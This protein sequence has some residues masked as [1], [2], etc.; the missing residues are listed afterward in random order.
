MRLDNYTRGTGS[1]SR[2]GT[3]RRVLWQAVAVAVAA[4][5][6]ALAC[7]PASSTPS[8]ASGQ[9]VI[10]PGATEP[11]TGPSAVPTATLVP[12]SGEPSLAGD[13]YL[14]MPISLEMTV[15]CGFCDAKGLL[16]RQP[17]FRLYADG[18]AVFREASVEESPYRYVQLGD[19]DFEALLRYALDEGGL[20][21]AEPRYP[22]DA[23]DIGG[24]R[25]ALHAQFI[26]DDADVDVEISP[27]TGDGDIDIHGDPIED[28]PRRGQLL[29]FAEV[30]GDFD[31]WLAGRGEASQLFVPESYRAA[32]VDRFAG[33][34]EGPWPWDDIAP[35]A[36]AAAGSGVSLAKISPAQAAQAG[37]GPG[38]GLFENRYLG[39]GTAATL[40]I[41]PVLPGE[42][43]PGGFGLQPDTVAI[44]V[45][46]DLRVRSLPEV[47][48]ASTKL[49]PLLR[50][51]DAL[52]VIVGPVVG[53]GYDWYEVYA[54]RTGLSGWVAAAAREGDDWIQP[55]PLTCTLGASPDAVVA[56]IG[57]ELMHLACY[58]GVEMGGVRFLGR[59]EGDGLRCP[60]VVEWWFAPE[61]LDGALTCS[62]E[63][64]PEEADTGSFDL[65]T[66]GAIHP[67]IA[68]VPEALLEAHPSG[69][70]VEIVGQLD[71]PDARA[72]QA[73][74]DNRPPPAL[75]RL[76]CRMVF[77]ITEMRPAT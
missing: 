43:R 29:E 61:W 28:L 4:T 34:G 75:A 68:D 21:G 33:D 24:F 66:G 47:S 59:P 1:R 23:D 71:H 15:D 67:S 6:L 64:R 77:V 9:P 36:F 50:A 19:D 45:E 44:A 18:T 55:V 30:L 3:D 48:D 17:R 73:V 40:L 72:C 57:Y 22:G 51:G 27:L 8:P 32:I 49:T 26:D 20:R 63:F 7:S 10:S 56:A 5:I 52:Y 58:G 41:E 14:D 16:E 76:L 60:D 54:P 65:V 2:D 11:A 62:Y 37:V 46:D 39:D 38:G 42:D 69:L 74:G 70:L 13:A 31:H 25:F 53:S 12:G 35:E